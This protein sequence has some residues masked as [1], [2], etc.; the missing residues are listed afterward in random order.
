MIKGWIT[1]EIKSEYKNGRV[2]VEG[3]IDLAD[4]KQV[5][6]KLK[7]MFTCYV[8]FSRT[9]GCSCGCSPGFILKDEKNTYAKTEF[10]V[11]LQK[12]GET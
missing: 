10:F 3:N 4:L 11:T 12:V 2:Y 9:A 5:R 6:K 8:S 1:K 7:E